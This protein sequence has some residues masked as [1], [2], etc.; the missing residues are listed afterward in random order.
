[1]TT[2]YLDIE[3][4]PA[5]RPDVLEEIR[6]AEQVKRDAA[7]AAVK[8]PA[9][10]GPE[11]A[12]KWMAEKG[13][14]Q[15]EAIAAGFDA[16]VE[17][18][19]RKTGL[20]GS[21]GQICVVGL[22]LD[23]GE[24]VTIAGMDETLILREFALHL[25]IIRVGEWHTTTIVGHNVANFD[26]RFLAQRSIV[27]GIRPHMIIARA[28]QAKPWEQE[29]VYDTMIQWAGV[30]TKISL[31]RLCKALG[32]PSPKGECDGTK[33]WDF[34]KAG[35]L[36]EVEAYCRGDVEAVRAIHRRMTFQSAP[37]TAPAFED[38]PA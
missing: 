24:P 38:V 25:G 36:A 21:F 18:A 28:A 27:R 8:A 19:Y 35:R 31:D 20:D 34:V 4:I 29:K 23:D 7:I 6:A 22:A 1:M 17:A 5:Q 33:V 26:L 16:E 14:A 13:C 2:L 32:I 30:G 9:N 12:A 3:T 10:Y 15:L 37:V 11:A